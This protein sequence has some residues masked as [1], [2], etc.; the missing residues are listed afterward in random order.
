MKIS[1]LTRSDKGKLAAV[2][3]AL[4][5]MLALGIALVSCSGAVSAVGIG[6]SR[7]VADAAGGAIEGIDAQEAVEAD[8]AEDD[9]AEQQAETAEPADDETVSHES[10]DTVNPPSAESGQPA[11]SPSHSESKSEHLRSRTERATEKVGRGHRAGLGRGQGCVDRER[12]RLLHRRGLDLQHLRPGRHGQ[13]LR[14]WEG[15]HEGR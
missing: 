13:H 15:P 6:V 14:A 10:V 1:D 12:P 9:P 3:A 5:V 4:A 8:D 7:A 11:S 2:C